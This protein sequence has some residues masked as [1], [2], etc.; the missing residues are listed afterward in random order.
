[1]TDRARLVYALLRTLL[2]AIP[3]PRA[4][5]SQATPGFRH[6]GR[7]DTCPDCLANGRVM[8]GCETCRGRGVVAPASPR[9]PYE[10]KRGGFFGDEK[11]QARDLEHQRDRE[12]ERID[13]LLAQHEG[14]EGQLDSL[15]RTL[16]LRERLLGLG[17]YAALE[18]ALERLR[19]EQPLAYRMAMSVC[20]QPF[21]EAP[22]EPTSAVVEKVCELLALRMEGEIRVP[23]FV[24]VSVDQE[25]ER[26]AR[27]GKG[28]LWWGR[29]D[30]HRL[31]RGERDALMVAMAAEGR[32]ATEIGLRFNVTRR[33]VQQ[34][35]AE[36]V[37][38]ASGPA[39]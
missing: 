16:V 30:W 29:R 39:A 19:G 21:G 3:G 28:A 2:V 8:P 27:E 34:L 26:V 18:A 11:Q 13:E 17:S 6:A 10:Q 36:R 37:G 7:Y 1:M 31:R 4:A 15:T 35:L 14:R 20:Y 5:R 23:R 12:I 32:S 25:V 33:R 24:T 22:V 38:Q 9:D